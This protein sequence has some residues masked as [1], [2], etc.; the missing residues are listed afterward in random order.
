MVFSHK[1][2]THFVIFGH[3]KLRCFLD[4]QKPRFWLH[5]GWVRGTGNGHVGLQEAS[6][7]EVKLVLK[8]FYEVSFWESEKKVRRPHSDTL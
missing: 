4:L 3:L 5:F 8:G 2:E 1:R 7:S 6:R